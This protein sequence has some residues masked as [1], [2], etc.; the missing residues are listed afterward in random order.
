MNLLFKKILCAIS[1]AIVPMA[2]RA[3]EPQQFALQDLSQEEQQML[4]QELI[5]RKMVV[6]VLVD[7]LRTNVKTIDWLL[8]NYTQQPEESMKKIMHVVQLHSKHR[9]ESILSAFAS[10]LGITNEADYTNFMQESA[11][12]LSQIVAPELEKWIYCSVNAG[13]MR[14]Q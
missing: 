3:E 9:W 1:L 2:M 8:E 4:Y 6:E 13:M 14:K 7:L 12:M 11:A 5:F 10:E